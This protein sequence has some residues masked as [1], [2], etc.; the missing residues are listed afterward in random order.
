MFH[1]VTGSNEVQEF[2]HSFTISSNGINDGATHA[3]DVTQLIADAAAANQEVF[4][5]GFGDGEFLSNFNITVAGLVAS[6]DPTVTGTVGGQVVQQ[7]HS[8]EPFSNVTLTDTGNPGGSGDDAM[9]TILDSNG[10]GTLALPGIINFK[11]FAPGSYQTGSYQTGSYQ[12]GS[13]QTGSYQTGSYHSLSVLQITLRSILSNAA[14]LPAGTAHIPLTLDIDIQSALGGAGEN[15]TTTIDISAACYCRG[16]R[17]LTSYGERPIETLAIGDI[18]ITEGG[19]AEPIR[20]IGRRTFAGRFLAGRKHLMPILFRAG[21]LGGGLPRRDLRVSPN[22]AMLLDG[23]LAPAIA[24]AN[25]TTIMQDRD[26][27]QVDYIHLELDRHDAILAEGAASETF[28]DDDS[29]GMFHDAADY[30]APEGAQPPALY[31]AP[32]V[33]SGARLEAIRR[34]LGALAQ[35][36]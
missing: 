27:R 18:V 21:S 8:I 23:L 20:W 36:G 1:F 12:T 19:A 17:I 25:H 10:N 35:T 29:R 32:R 6:G 34:R 13:Y 5:A 24:L 7:K 33:E 30:R 2:N 11:S 22:H 28:L 9:L 4:F 26:C 14:A 16:T 3:Y 31:C 15:P